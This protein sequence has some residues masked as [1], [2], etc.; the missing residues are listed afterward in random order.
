MK[1]IAKF[2]TN[3]KLNV[4]G[5]SIQWRIKRKQQKRN[6]IFDTANFKKP[7]RIHLGPGPN[8]KKP[9]DHWID[10]DIDPRWGD[11][12]IDFQ[13]FDGFPLPTASVE[14]IYGS[15]VFEHMSIWVTNDVFAECCRILKPQGTMRLI[16]PDAEKSIK[17]YVAGNQNFDLFTRRKERARTNYGL[18]YTLFDCLREDFLS[19]SGQTDLLGKNALAHQNAWDFEAIKNDLN[20]AGF[21]QVTRCSFRQSASTIFNFEGSYKSEACETNRSLYVEAIK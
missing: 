17:E 13:N 10:V 15:H 3:G 4:P 11:L 8:W 6:E 1:K 5:F 18:N 2:I 14:C 20:R 12:V 19:R 21:S 9:D 16:L 7:Y